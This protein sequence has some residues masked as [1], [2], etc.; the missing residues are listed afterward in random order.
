MSISKD[1]A[2][3]AGLAIKF[4]A[5]GL[6]GFVVDAVL[7][8][9]GLCLH[10]GPAWARLISLTLAMQ[11]TFTINRTH[12]FACSGREGLLRQWCAYMATNGFGNLCNYWIFVTLGSLH[13]SLVSKPFVA[14]P[15]SAFAAY[16]INY[17]GVR[18]VVFGR[19]RLRRRAAARAFP[20]PPIQE[21][22]K[23]VA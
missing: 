14:L 13:E 5:V 4:A 22:P 9:V 6:V 11:V 20:R 15:I 21:S 1:T 3:E 19:T 2:E 10:L 12:V 23:S 7:L 16:L 18:L 8:K 17:A